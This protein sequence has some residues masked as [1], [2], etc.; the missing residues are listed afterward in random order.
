MGST[1]STE[2]RS[3]DSQTQSPRTRSAA[4]STRVTCQPVVANY[5]RD[6]VHI[7][8]ASLAAA[9]VDA[10]APCQSE[11]HCKCDKHIV[12]NISALNNYRALNTYSVVCR[13]MVQVHKRC[14]GMYAVSRLDAADGGSTHRT[15]KPTVTF[16]RVPTVDDLRQEHL[17]DF[18]VYNVELA[19]YGAVVL[20]IY[21][22]YERKMMPLA[23]RSKSPV[24]EIHPSMHTSRNHEASASGRRCRRNTDSQLHR[25]RRQAAHVKNDQHIAS[26]P[27]TASSQVDLSLCAV[28]LDAPSTHAGVPCGHRNLCAK[29]AARLWDANNHAC[30]ICTLLVERYISIF[31]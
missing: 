6:A 19:M 28:C 30:P 24:A 25:S 3:R 20:N 22:L 29:C 18:D 13:D 26:V 1:A 16:A 8:L 14:D 27:P 23:S 10:Q 5:A 12:V 15:R 2:T 21:P 7:A 4:A 31:V 11:G 9:T 17:V